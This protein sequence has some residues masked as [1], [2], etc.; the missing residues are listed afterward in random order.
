MTYLQRQVVMLAKRLKHLDSK[1]FTAHDHAALWIL[2]RSLP[3]PSTSIY[4]V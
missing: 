2:I 1:L 3:M 4:E